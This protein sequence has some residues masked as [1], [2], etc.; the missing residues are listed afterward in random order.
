MPSGGLI[1]HVLTSAKEGGKL[2]SSSFGSFNPDKRAPL[3]FANLKSASSVRMRKK[4]I[5]QGLHFK[6]LNQLDKYLCKV[7]VKVIPQQV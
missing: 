3:T 2:S 5:F 6:E 1:P 4:C 7:K